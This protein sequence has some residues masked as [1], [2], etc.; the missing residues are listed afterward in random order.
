MDRESIK[1]MAAISMLHFTEEEL[2]RFEESF[3]E[4]MDIIDRIKKWDTSGLEE[5]FH[6]NQMDNHLREDSIGESL[7]QNLA[8]SNSKTEKYGYFEI[9]K[10]VD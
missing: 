2:D 1:K 6:V 4:T 5:T 10:F 7:E 9:I 8:T 3:S